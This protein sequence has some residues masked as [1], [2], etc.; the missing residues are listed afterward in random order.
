MAVSH[1]A[2]NH[3]RHYLQSGDQ[4]LAI[5]IHERLP[6]NLACVSK[7]LWRF[8][9]KNGAEDLG[10]AAW[11]YVRE[12]NRWRNMNIFQRACMRLWVKYVVMRYMRREGVPWRSLQA[13]QYFLADCD[14]TALAMIAA[15]KDLLPA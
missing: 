2:V 14:G 13:I 12:R 6:F 9:E 3:P 5:S 10:K 11:F 4:Y 7:Y 8:R 1:D 15:A